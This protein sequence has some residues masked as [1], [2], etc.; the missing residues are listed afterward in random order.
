MILQGK[1]WIRILSR[2]SKRQIR[3]RWALRARTRNVS[4][5]GTARNWEAA[6]EIYLSVWRRHS[7]FSGSALPKS[8]TQWGCWKLVGI[9]KFAQH[10][11]RLVVLYCRI[12]HNGALICNWHMHSDNK[13]NTGRNWQVLVFIIV[14][15]SEVWGCLRCKD[16]WLSKPAILFHTSYAN[17]IFHMV[18]SHVKYLQYMWIH[19]PAMNSLNTQAFLPC[20]STKEYWQFSRHSAI[21]I[22][23]QSTL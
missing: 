19:C 13:C 16:N 2:F 14:K 20:S 3:V 18:R 9:Q 6:P 21:Q 22:C 8:R 7:A 1:S 15:K 23:C 4:S 17:N 10:A 11:F 5:A 12:A